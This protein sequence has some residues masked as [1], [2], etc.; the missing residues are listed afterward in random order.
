M[1]GSSA[2][3][4]DWGLGCAEGQA[5][6]LPWFGEEVPALRNSSVAYGELL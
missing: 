2:R 6:A 1:G 4:V 3:E 5:E